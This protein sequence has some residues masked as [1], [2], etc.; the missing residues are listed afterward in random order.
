MTALGLVSLMEEDADLL[1]PVLKILS[2]PLL[3]KRL[4]RDGRNLI[5]RLEPTSK[6]TPTRMNNLQQRKILRIY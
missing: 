5:S 4:E 2:A 1:G 6:I 3:I